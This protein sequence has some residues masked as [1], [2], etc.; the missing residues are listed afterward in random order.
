MLKV[1]N[2]KTTA[3]GVCGLLT[4]LGSLGGDMLSGN[5]ATIPMHL[6]GIAASIGLIFAS[7]A[8]SL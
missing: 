8:K 3:L 2:W 1:T 5:F 7:D 6:P 4:A